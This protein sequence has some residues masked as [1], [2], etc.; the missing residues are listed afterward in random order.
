MELR[1]YLKVIRTRWRLLALGLVITVVA[2]LA[3]SFMQKRVYEGQAEVIVLEQQNSSAILLGSAQD[4]VASQPDQAYVLTQ[5]QVIQSSSIAQ[6]VIRSLGLNTTATNLLKR[7]TA[8]TDGQSNIVTIVA[9]DGSAESAAKTANAFAETYV[10]WSRDSQIAS[11]KAS[12]D[13]IQQRMDAAQKQIVALTNPKGGATTSTRSQLATA[14]ALHASLASKLEQLRINQDL[15]SGSASVLA[16]AAVDLNPVSSSHTRDAGLGLAI[17]LLVGLGMVFLAEQL[18]TK[19]RSSAEVEEIYGAPVLGSIPTEK[20]DKK[21]TTRLTLVQRPGSSAAEAYRS[22]GIGLEFVNFKHDVKTLLVTSAV[23]SEGKSTV[24]ANLSVALSQAGS[25]V[26]LLSCDFHRP[27]TATFFDLSGSIG[28]SDVLTGAHE[29]SEALQ[30]SESFERLTV[31]SAGKTPPN[32]S[33][34]LGS[35]RME[36][37]VGNLR[38]SADW[39]ILDAPPVLAVADAAAVTRLADGVLVVTR[40]GVTTREE[41]KAARDQLANIGARIL[42]LAVWDIKDDSVA[43]RT[44]SGYTSH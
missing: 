20:F 4:Q 34:L 11:L 33:E 25:T 28:L 19:I 35:S 14:E 43:V 8:T 2:A 10:A 12:G 42:G 40:V 13:Q 23:P 3:I 1:D 18:D 41:S 36:A 24:A 27:A 7:V 26:T 9:L 15:A 16:S 39:I 6:K 22:L 32:P 5:A 30:Q 21:E 37:V 44:Y 38:E 31:V 29:I 17:G